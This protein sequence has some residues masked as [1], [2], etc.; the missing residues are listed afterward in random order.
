KAEKQ[1]NQIE[2]DR[3][4]EESQGATYEYMKTQLNRAETI[5]NQGTAL[6]EQAA[7]LKMKALTTTD[8]DA[9]AKMDAEAKRLSETG[10]RL[11]ELA[12][13]AQRALKGLNDSVMTMR[14]DFRE[15]GR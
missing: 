12:D 2:A 7:Q 4:K 3:Q 5:R 8:K 1:G 14:S 6:I 9:A 15:K 10:T 11:I 13:G